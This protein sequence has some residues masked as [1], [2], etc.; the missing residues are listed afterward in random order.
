MT[1]KDIKRTSAE[2][3]KKLKEKQP[4]SG[5]SFEDNSAGVFT[6]NS[7]S[8]DANNTPKYVD[9]S[10]KV[11][12]I[13]MKDDTVKLGEILGFSKTATKSTSIYDVDKETQEKRHQLLSKI[14]EVITMILKLHPDVKELM[15]VT[16]F[17][18][19]ENRI[20]SSKYYKK[21]SKGLT[22]TDEWSQGKATIDFDAWLDVN[23]PFLTQTLY[24][25]KKS[26]SYKDSSSA[27]TGDDMNILNAAY[28][29]YKKMLE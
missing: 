1:Q 9:E 16:S 14:I 5:Y 25:Y 2:L 11:K 4:I 27:L 7:L 23:V 22:L 10:M 21:Y 19:D 20:M 18:F 3:I 24:I 6:P 17:S 26:L 15:G 12:I 13:Q 29:Y 8:Y 28:I